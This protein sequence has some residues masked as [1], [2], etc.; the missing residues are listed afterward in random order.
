VI[1][2]LQDKLD[3][4]T[5]SAI[6]KLQQ[7]LPA[8]ITKSVK[9]IKSS[10]KP[11][12]GD[13]GDIG[14]KGDRGNGIKDAKIDNRDH[15]I[16]KTDDKVID[17][18]E[19]SKKFFSSFGFSY[20]TELPMPFD[21]GGFKKG[22]RF[23]DVDLKVLWTKLLY[24]YD[25]PYFSAFIGFLPEQ[26]EV[27]YKIATG[28][29]PVSFTITNPEL[30]KED[31]IT[32]SLNDNPLLTNLPNTSPV[33]LVLSE[34]IKRDLIGAV[35]F[36]IR[37]YDTT[38]TSFSK[39]LAVNYMHKV[40]WGAYDVDINDNGLPNPLKVFEGAGVQGGTALEL[41]IVD[42]EYVFVDLTSVLSAVGYRWFCYPASLGDNYVFYDE[43]YSNR[44]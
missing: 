1:S 30:L 36:E 20:T 2:A 3:D 18:G 11:I 24:G 10:F 35:S 26:V 34:D 16:I 8:F 31:S 6:D 19:V 37:A 32:L 29:Y 43:R 7:D 22:A 23:K 33:D 12:K 39:S 27:G 40:Y 14:S 13:K 38:G 21:V 17:A 9:D 5:S 25:L 28:A 4:F 15:L 42:T 44:L 41:S